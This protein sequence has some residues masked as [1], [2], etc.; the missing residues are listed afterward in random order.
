MNLIDLSGLW[1]CEIPGFRG[2]MRLPGTLD[3]NGIPTRKTLKKL[4]IVD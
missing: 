4:G 3:E 2:Q 1:A